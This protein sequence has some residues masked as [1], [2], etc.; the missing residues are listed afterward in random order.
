MSRNWYVHVVGYEERTSEVTMATNVCDT[1]VNIRQL[2]TKI[3]TRCSAH[4][5]H[6]MRA[7]KRILF[8]IV[9]LTKSKCFGAHSINDLLL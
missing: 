1:K 5:P 9:G 8:V 7:K 4:Q 6:E 2:K 3:Q